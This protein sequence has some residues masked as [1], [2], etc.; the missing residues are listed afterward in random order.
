MESN[1]TEYLLNGLYLLVVILTL[2]GAL[3]LF[4]ALFSLIFKENKIKILSRVFFSLLLLFFSLFFCQYLSLSDV[5]EKVRY[6]LFTSSL[7]LIIGVGA[8]LLDSFIKVVLWSEIASHEDVCTVPPMV[9]NLT[10][11]AIYLFASFIVI[12]YIFNQ[13]VT[14]L[15]AISGSLIFILGL[16]AQSVASDFFSGLGLSLSRNIRIG[17]WHFLEG[18]II[19]KVTEANWRS[20]TMEA[21]SGHQIVFPNTVIAKKMLNN[22]SWADKKQH[23]WSVDFQVDTENIP[24]SVICRNLELKAFE[25]PYISNNPAPVCHTH[26]ITE[27]GICFQLHIYAHHSNWWTSYD[28]AVKSAWQVV[29]DLG[30][31]LSF[32]NK[33]NHKKSNLVE[34]FKE[35]Y[36]KVDPKVVFEKISANTFFKVLKRVDQDSLVANSSIS[37]FEV[38][39]AIV[40]QGDIGDSLYLIVRGS[41]VVYIKQDDQV[42]V[43]VATLNEGDFFGH[44]S[45]FLGQKRNATV[46]VARF[47]QTIVVNKKIFQTIL[48]KNPDIV[49]DLAHQISILEEQNLLL[50]EEHNIKTAGE[51]EDHTSLKNKF[52]NGIKKFYNL[53]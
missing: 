31:T 15:A 28:D 10:S 23:R 16:G 2:A 41:A 53:I 52:I 50:L 30:L 48:E 14:A 26:K 4:M 42:E 49:E 44:V 40:K 17:D 34:D 35:I 25:S 27:L 8:L 43:K 37:S 51:K 22:L 45:L 19:A 29:N 46:R 13:P 5:Y 18:D 11:F 36:S 39:D 32:Q 9:I 1:I 12:R 6:F 21:G 33:I 3:G 24:P 38:P 20:V 47:C 7:F